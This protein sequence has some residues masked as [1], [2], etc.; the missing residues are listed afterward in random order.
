[1][2]VSFALRNEVLDSL[3]T[4]INCINC[5][6]MEQI[7][8]QIAIAVEHATGISL[9]QIKGRSRKEEVVEARKIFAIMY[10]Q[11][12]QCK[13]Y[14][15]AAVINRDRSSVAYYVSMH[16]AMYGSDKIYTKKYTNCVASFA[17]LNKD[18]LSDNRSVDEIQIKI[19]AME[20]EL[21]KL[22]LLLT[23]KKTMKLWE[24]AKTK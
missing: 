4:N 10:M 23:F 20:A 6:T 24:E 13:D 19:D 18:Y 5:T 12:M 16:N 22:R 14:D 2:D 3:C 9:L 7:T 11:A 21:S 17:V 15:A 1:M 8:N